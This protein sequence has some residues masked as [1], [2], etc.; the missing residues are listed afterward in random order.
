MT[1]IALSIGVTGILVALV[2]SGTAQPPGD[3][4]PKKGP[5]EWGKKGP[6]PPPFHM[7]KLVPPEICDLLDLSEDQERQIFDL[8]REF[9]GK[10]MKILTDDQKKLLKDMRTHRPPPPFPPPPPKDRDGPPDGDGPK[11]NQNERPRG[12]W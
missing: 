8:E 3:K 4:G 7:G 11:R 6:P 5:P 9:K 12:V 10:L 1:K 2:L